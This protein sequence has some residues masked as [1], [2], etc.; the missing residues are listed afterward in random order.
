MGH[1]ASAVKVGKLSADKV[2]PAEHVRAIRHALSQF[3]EHAP[4]D[5]ILAKC[6]KDI[7]KEEVYFILNSMRP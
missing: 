7:K 2:I 1:L 5:D 6:P 3:E 4:V